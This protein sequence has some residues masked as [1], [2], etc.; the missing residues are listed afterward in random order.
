MK[1]RGIFDLIFQIFQQIILKRKNLTTCSAY[2]MVMMMSFF[3]IK[4]GL[5][6]G[7]IAPAG[8]AAAAVAE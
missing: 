7:D 3:S 1:S 5:L 2:Q 4:D 8:S 6:P